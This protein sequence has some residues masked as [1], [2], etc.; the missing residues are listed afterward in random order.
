LAVASGATPIGNAGHVPDEIE[1]AIVNILQVLTQL[2]I[3][4]HREGKIERNIDISYD[5]N[6]FAIPTAEKYIRQNILRA[7]L[8]QFIL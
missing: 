5:S 8:S 6:K 4:S 2:F 3:Y 1:G 7:P